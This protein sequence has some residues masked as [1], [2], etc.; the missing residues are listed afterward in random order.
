M[1]AVLLRARALLRRRWHAWVALG[2]V[3]GV[4]AGIAM[5]LAQG[6]HSS[7]VA[8]PRFV[9]SER[10]A[11]LVLAG[12]SDFSAV[13]SV[14]VDKVEL[15]PGVADEAR[16]FAAVPMSAGADGGRLLGVGDILPVASVDGR[17]GLAIERWK[18]LEGRRADPKRTDE[19]VASFELAS[20]LKLRV[21]SVLQFHFFDKKTFSTVEASLLTKD[22]PA[23]LDAVRRD[24]RTDV[25][26]PANGPVVQTRI[27]GIEASPLEF[28][29]ITTDLAPALHLTPAFARTYGSLI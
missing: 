14:D 6:A 15:L 28:P 2:I 18:M 26:D 9:R 27:V 23:R 7:Q 17:L 1:T 11:D 8:Y 16:G 29:P 24:M 20:R 25:T 12:R 4:F 5:A 10:A 3:I 13:G 21:G 22:W 19:A